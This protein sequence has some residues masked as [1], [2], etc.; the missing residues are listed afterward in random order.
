MNIGLKKAFR[1]VTILALAELVI[2][3][4]VGT[5]AWAV[6]KHDLNAL[7]ETFYGSVRTELFAKIVGG[8]TALILA[9]N[10]FSTARIAIK[11]EKFVALVSLLASAGVASFFF[12][13]MLCT[14][15]GL[16]GVIGLFIAF[17]ALALVWTGVSWP[18]RKIFGRKSKDAVAATA[19]QAKPPTKAS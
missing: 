2:T 7:D 18:F 16:G 19:P 13:P 11:G 5:I 6:A 1:A 8:F 15:Y 12:L 14:V 4:L 9:V 10:L 3:L 17:K